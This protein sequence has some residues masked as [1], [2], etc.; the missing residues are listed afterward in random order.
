MF[1][2]YFAIIF[3]ARTK[4]ENP[5]AL[6]EQPKK[7]KKVNNRSLFRLETEIPVTIFPI[8]S[9]VMSKTKYQ[10]KMIDLSGTGCKVRLPDNKM[11]ETDKML[12][13]FNLHKI[14][15]KL[16]ANVVRWNAGKRIIAMKFTAPYEGPE[17]ENIDPLAWIEERIIQFVFEQQRA[18]NQLPHFYRR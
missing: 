9:E 15:F 14:K 10:T 17:D 1:G 8:Y 3:L 12:I 11:S 16:Y 6:S 2:K 7:P 13:E 4:G 5:M 18:S